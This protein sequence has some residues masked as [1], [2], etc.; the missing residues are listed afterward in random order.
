MDPPEDTLR[1]YQLLSPAQGLPLLTSYHPTIVA[2]I[3]SPQVPLV[4]VCV[5]PDHTLGEWQ[6][7]L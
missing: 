7:H 5:K 4:M 2:I 6:G 1:L 3:I